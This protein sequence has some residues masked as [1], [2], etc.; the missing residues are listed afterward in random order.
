[1]SPMSPM[2]MLLPMR[3]LLL[4][5]LPLLLGLPLS[6]DAQISPPPPLPPP[7][8]PPAPPFT[9]IGSSCSIETEP[10]APDLSCFGGACRTPLPPGEACPASNSFCD[11]ARNVCGEA[12]TCVVRPANVPLG[13]ACSAATGPCAPCTS[14]FGGTCQTPLS[15]GQACPASNSFCDGACNVCGED[16]TCVARPVLPPNVPL[17][18]PCSNTSEACAPGTS[19]QVGICQ[20]PLAVGEPCGASAAAAA[21]GASYC[22]S[23][24][25]CD[26]VLERCVVYKGFA[27]CA[28]DD[29]CD[30]RHCDAG[31]CRARPQHDPCDTTEDCAGNLTCRVQPSAAAA[32]S[33]PRT[34]LPAYVYRALGERCIADWDCGGMLA[35][36]AVPNTTSATAAPDVF[37][38][39]VR[40]P[41]FVGLPEGW[42]CNETRDCLGGSIC[43]PPYESAT[44][45][46]LARG[47][48]FRCQA[49]LVPTP[50]GGP[51]G[52][53]YECGAPTAGLICDRT[54]LPGGNMSTG[55][56]CRLPEL[57]LPLGHPCANTTE[58]AG[59]LL[60]G[61]DVPIPDPSL[62][63]LGAAGSFA[64]LTGTG[65]TNAGTLSI[66]G[67]DIGVWPTT[68]GSLTGFAAAG[69]SSSTTFEGTIVC[70]DVTTRLS[71]KFD[72]V[73]NATRLSEAMQAIVAVTEELG[74]R[75]HA[76]LPGAGLTEIG[77]M[78]LPAGTYFFP[79]TLTI[80]TDVIL[81]GSSTDVWIFKV[82]ST[83][84]VAAGARV[85]LVGGARAVNIYWQIGTT[86]A[87]A[88]GVVIEGT[89]L[90]GTTLTLGVDCTVR[91]R[92]FSK[93]AVTIAAG[94]VPSA[95]VSVRSDGNMTSFRCLPLLNLVSVTRAPC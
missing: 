65:I 10:Y 77:G 69:P 93:T 41:P 50:Y 33:S 74:N 79:A 2:S 16:G 78:T 29:D 28:S 91:G 66:V 7:P 86:C 26:A 38:A 64:I 4:L 73:V 13:D 25:V 8:P 30:S 88:A 1:M 62:V 53:D 55:K 59:G 40:R 31:D 47:P 80:T 58:C 3:L 18:G 71:S 32:A 54:P 81:N 83:A 67:G 51:C 27:S 48:P 45:T 39:A 61:S 14:C 85:V 87:L 6:C 12:G 60:C 46:A 56:V 35:C 19:C 90:V 37:T 24:L 17:A 34:C 20:V 95:I 76:T 82:Y 94:P 49:P 70:P 15:I 11:G 22:G 36:G 5:L 43:S 42:R 57:P 21:G 72:S 23:M 92:I 44:R 75:A 9:S 89:M 52:E 68:C 84:A 63:D